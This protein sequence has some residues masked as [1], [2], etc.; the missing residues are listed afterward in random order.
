M[1]THFRVLT[2]CTGNIGRSPMAERLLRHRLGQR[3]G[4]DATIFDVSSAGT[5]G[6]VG[7]PMEEFAAAALIESGVSAS[8]F[9]GRALDV[10]LL[11]DVDLVLTATRDHRAE[12]V[13]LLPNVV[14]R[15]FTIKEFARLSDA[16]NSAL[17][18]NG[19]HDLVADARGR[20]DMAGR[21]RG[22]G[23]RPDP[24]DEDVV[25]PIGA[26]LDTYRERM[27]EIDRACARAVDL[28]LGPAY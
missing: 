26:P 28:L 4:P 18:P 21:L 9:R 25:D 15:A 12:V 10:Q 23:D 16:V 17:G 1:S 6:C 11:S 3:L 24:A 14:R 19:S 20:T 22:M 13:A 8:G 27:A 7:E 2:V 5:L